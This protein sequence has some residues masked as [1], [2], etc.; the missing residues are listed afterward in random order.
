MRGL[1][2]GALLALLAGCAAT[3]QTDRLA[4]SP[5][6]GLP[7]RTELTQTP[8]H[9]QERYQCGPA[10]LATVLT[11]AGLE[12]TPEQ[13]VSEVYLPARK[14]ALAPEL[15]AAARRHGALPYPLEGGMS[16]LLEELA[17]GYPVL[18]LQ[19]LGLS[20]WPQWHFAVAV[21]YDLPRETVVLRSGTEARHE[22]TLAT[23]EH[24]WRRA[25]YWGLVV[26]PPD[27]IPATARPLRYLQAAEPF[28]Q[29][30]R[31][32]IAEAAYRAAADRWPDYPETGLGLGN[33]HFAQGDLNAAA[34]AYRRVLV[35]FPNY[36]PALN[37]LAQS[38]LDMGRPAEAVEYAQQAVALGGPFSDQYRHTLNAVL[39]AQRP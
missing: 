25:D 24:T 35:H 17:A 15:S 36:A 12:I 10:A 20:W 13:L 21:G 38:L 3:P 37:N 31:Y 27:R 14:G 4:V 8:F 23:F 28:E 16:A 22:L 11:A 18:V 7:A 30:G 32:R 26:V 1:F 34:T 33:L 9:P 6:A 19:N 2:A 5:P 39:A 29:Q